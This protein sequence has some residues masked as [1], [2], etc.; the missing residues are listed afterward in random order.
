MVGSVPTT[1][2]HS[3]AMSEP[4]SSSVHTSS[5]DV[6]DLQDAE[7]LTPENA[8]TTLFFSISTDREVY[9]GNDYVTGTVNIQSVAPVVVPR[10]CVAVMCRYV[11]KN[12]VSLQYRKAHTIFRCM[13]IIG[14]E[15]SVPAGSTSIPFSFM[16]PT[17]MPA[18][19]QHPLCTVR[20][21]IR[22]FRY[23]RQ[24]N[25]AL[26]RKSFRM[27]SLYYPLPGLT[28]TVQAERPSVFNNSTVVRVEASVSKNIY[29]AD[30]PIDLHIAFHFMKKTVRLR[31]VSA[32]VVQKVEHHEADQIL[33]RSC[34]ILDKSTLNSSKWK[35]RSITTKNGVALDHTFALLLTSKVSGDTCVAVQGND[36]SES[37]LVPTTHTRCYNSIV[38]I[39]VTYSVEIS[40]SLCGAADIELS[41]PIIVEGSTASSVRAGLDP[42][43]LEDCK[44]FPTVGEDPPE[45]E[46]HRISSTCS[47]T[48]LRRDSADTVFSSLVDEQKAQV[49]RYASFPSLLSR[50]KSLVGTRNS[51]LIQGAISESSADEEEVRLSTPYAE[52]RKVCKIKT[53]DKNNVGRSFSMSKLFGRQQASG[54]TNKDTGPPSFLEAV[55]FV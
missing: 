34:V 26:T 9:Y 18:S 11:C 44:T 28:P 35:K 20:W 32:S 14:R 36:C 37:S 42:E 10:I 3:S 47:Y 5:Y 15:Y 13:K 17:D 8:E 53:A 51:S 4:L 1:S 33:S 12:R 24:T 2:S 27:S 23:D 22:L 38:W 31:K 40:I 49:K 21:D 16:L 43:T 52:N 54:M 48:S 25:M 29:T 7:K 41:I 39:L 6:C 50:T 46:H 55:Q 45:Y 30:N 19:M